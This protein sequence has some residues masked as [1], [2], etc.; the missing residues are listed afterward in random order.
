MFPAT[1]YRRPPGNTRSLIGTGGGSGGL[2]GA[3]G[4][5]KYAPHCM[6]PYTGG[7]SSSFRRRG[8]SNAGSTISVQDDLRPYLAARQAKR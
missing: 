7:R 2:C 6:S 3:S 4:P 5:R 1:S 8:Q